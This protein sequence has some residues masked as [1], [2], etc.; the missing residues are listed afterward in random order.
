MPA[1]APVRNHDSLLWRRSTGRKQVHVATSPGGSARAGV[2]CRNP[3]DEEKFWLIDDAWIPTTLPQV[4]SSAAGEPPCQQPPWAGIRRAEPTRR[5]VLSPSSHRL[6]GVRHKARPPGRRPARGPPNH[7]AG[8]T[9]LAA[10]H[11]HGPQARLYG[12]RSS[13]MV[14]V[15]LPSCPSCLPCLPAFLSSCL[16]PYELRAAGL[17]EANQSAERSEIPSD[18]TFADAAF[19]AR[20]PVLIPRSLPKGVPSQMKSVSMAAGL[21]P[22]DYQAALPSSLICRCGPAAASASRVVPQLEA[23]AQRPSCRDTS[24]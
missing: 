22:R 24:S 15:F 3:R 9:V 10:L 12:V 21:E 5:A 7:T 8:N 19:V 17:R 23:V 2:L 16:P 4:R 11:H 1:M 20:L 14:F 18:V 13:L 6:Y